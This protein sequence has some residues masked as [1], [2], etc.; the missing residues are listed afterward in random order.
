MPRQYDQTLDSPVG[1]VRLVTLHDTNDIATGVPKGFW[2]PVAG[3]ADII[4]ESDHTIEDFEFLAGVNPFRFKRI[5]A[6]GA[7]ITKIYALYD[8]DYY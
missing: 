8:A 3:T 1:K 7:T 5:K 2:C 4:D 6:T